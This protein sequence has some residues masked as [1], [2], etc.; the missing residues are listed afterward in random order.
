MAGIE[1]DLQAELE[2]NPTNVT[3]I[4]DYSRWVPLSRTRTSA[5]VKHAELCTCENSPFPCGA[6]PWWES[7]LVELVRHDVHRFLRVVL[8]DE[9]WVAKTDEMFATAMEADP[10]NVEAYFR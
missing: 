2:S 6:G 3:C 9:K 10:K 4:L 1:R 5:C 8:E 7:A